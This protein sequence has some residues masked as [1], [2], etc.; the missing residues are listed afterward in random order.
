MG[1]GTSVAQACGC[2]PYGAGRKQDELAA[3]GSRPPQLGRAARLASLHDKFATVS[4]VFDIDLEALGHGSFGSVLRGTHRSTGA[5]RAIKAISK[6]TPA[7]VEQFRQEIALMKALDHPSI[8]KLHETFEDPKYLYLVM[9]LC[10]GGEL[11]DAVR[12]HD[13]GFSEV[14]AA[15]LMRQILRGV[16]YMHERAICHRD[17]KPENF[18]FQSK[19]DIRTTSLKMIDFGFACRFTPGQF[20]KT[21]IGTPYYVAPEVLSGRYSHL[22][23]LWSCGVILHMLLCG[24]APFVGTTQQRLLANVRRGRVHFDDADWSQIS[25][26]AKALVCKMMTLDASLRCSADEALGH[27]WFDEAAPESPASLKFSAA[28]A[29]EFESFNDAEPEGDADPQA[30]GPSAPDAHDGWLETER[31][32]AC[33][34]DSKLQPAAEQVIVRQ[35]DDKEIEASRKIF[36]TLDSDS[37]GLLALDD[38]KDGLRLAGIDTRP[39]EAGETMDVE[40]GD[41]S[42]MIDY[43][44]FLAR[45]VALPERNA[46]AE[47]AY[48]GC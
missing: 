45:A 2:V 39:S 46:S 21:R 6:T 36:I 20:M 47:P 7:L 31:L 35:L 15:T 5:S 33:K 48:G 17:L 3:M 13:L 30:P 28:E 1:A 19:G 24:Y 40:D 41:G 12:D 23:D 42:G 38:F 22:C 43:T 4:A 14:D 26:D 18:M 32:R 11:Y 29:L 16:C 34:P 37:D 27:S 8:V 25:S 44:A 9:D 10:E